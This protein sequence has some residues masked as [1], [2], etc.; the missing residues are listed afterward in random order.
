MAAACGP[1]RGPAGDAAE[2]RIELAVLEDK[3]R[4]GW[5]GQMI[6]VTYGAP[7]EFQYLE[8]LVP[9]EAIPPWQPERVRGALEQDDLYVDITLAEV[10]DEHGLDATTEQFG[11]LFREARYPLWHGNLAARRALRRGVP[12]T[13]S[14]TPRHNVHANDIDFQIEADFIGL[15]TPGMPRASNELCTRAGRVMSHGDGLYGGMFVSAM[16]AAAFFEH[17][18]RRIVEA[19]LAALPPESPYARVIADVLAWS[20]E[21]PDDWI[22]VWRLVNETWSRREPCSQGALDPFNIDAKINGAYVTLGLLHGGSDFAGEALVVRSQTAEPAVLEIWDDYG[23]PVERILTG[24]ERWRWQGDR[25]TPRTGRPAWSV[26]GPS[27]G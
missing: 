26:R 14:G 12:A 13:E 25:F 8:R 15:M 27:P 2:R 21:H 23:T 20:S 16:Y 11:E 24:D 18:P 10:L 6:G 19:G 9:E 3:I 5:A 1:F 7:T 17:E 22:R 4:G